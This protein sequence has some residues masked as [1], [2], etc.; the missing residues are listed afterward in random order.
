MNIEKIPNWYAFVTKPRH[1]KKVKSYLD[2]AGISS[3]LPMQ[4]TLHQWR[5]RKKWVEAP[6]FSCYIFSHIPYIYRYDVL[7]LPSVVRMV[8]FNNRPSPVRGEEIEA[9]TRFLAANREIDVVDG[10]LPGDFI[11]I[12]T[13]VLAGQEGQLVEYRGS[14]WFEI[15]ISA[16]GKS[17]LIDISRNTLA[18]L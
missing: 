8:G 1:E 6:L 16:I 5:D 12:T 7:K 18:K 15:Y 17:V 4:K 9:I 2:G 10:L 13:G 14:K 3:Y 11:R